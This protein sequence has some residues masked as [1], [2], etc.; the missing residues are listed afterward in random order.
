MIGISSFSKHSFIHD[1][2]LHFVIILIFVGLTVIMT[3]P[4]SAN[5]DSEIAGQGIGDP[6][7]M[8]WRFWM[9]KF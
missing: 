5:F 6:L 2:K 7:H 9:I 3:W 4:V 8:L 1:M